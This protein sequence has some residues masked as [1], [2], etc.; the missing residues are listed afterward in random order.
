MHGGE[1]LRLLLTEIPHP[2]GVD[3]AGVYR[4]LRDLET[5][6]Q[7]RSEWSTEG[8]GP[9]RRVYRLTPLGQAALEKWKEDVL[10]R[11]VNLGFFLEEYDR[12]PKAP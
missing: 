12:L 6:D 10:R 8:S 1:L 7:I 3:S 2:L 4:A 9:P 11:R 5:G